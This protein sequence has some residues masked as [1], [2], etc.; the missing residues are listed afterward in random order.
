MRSPRGVVRRSLTLLASVAGAALLIGLVMYAG[1]AQLVHQLQT[2]GPLL[3]VLLVLTGVRYFL[4]AAGWR[5]AIAPADLSAGADREG[6]PLSQHR[7][8]GSHSDPTVPKAERPGTAGC[9]SAVVV[10]EALGY[11]AWGSLARE[12]AKA[13]FLRPSVPPG[14]ALTG[15]LVERA[16]FVL[17]A[18]AL[19][20]VAGGVLVWR[21]RSFIWLTAAA[22]A[23]V[24]VAATW[25]TWR[26]T[27][28]P[29]F[30][31]LASAVPQVHDRPTHGRGT[32]IPLAVVRDLWHH[33][34][35]AILGIGG[36]A[37]AQEAIN[38]LETYLIFTWLGAGPTVTVAI[39][40]EGLSRFVN[41]AGQFVPGRLGV[42]EAASAFLADAL[43]LG[44]SFGVSLALARRT[45][46]LLWA[47]P[48]ALL[49][50][51]RGYRRFASS[52]GRNVAAGACDSCQTI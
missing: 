25:R 6:G 33:R 14:V 51:H 19:A 5:L 44:G 50:A 28:A 32:K 47:A 3:P 13:L 52:A 9:F 45:R 2:L 4:Q 1:P 31:R 26:P 11:V 17:S 49:L 42:Y 43:A 38:V 29:H 40:F 27:A 7:L 46:S 30:D 21:H 36:L 37:I 18:T 23:A 35:A 15:A 8:V 24:T 20:V 12:P 39:V 22:A 48:G 16:I 41:A 34:R 10:G